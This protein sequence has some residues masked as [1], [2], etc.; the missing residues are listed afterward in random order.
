MRYNLYR[1]TGEYKINFQNGFVVAYETSYQNM[2]HDIN[3]NKE[4]KNVNYKRVDSLGGI[5]E[6]EEYNLN[7][8]AGSKAEND[9]IPM[10]IEIPEGTIYTPEVYFGIVQN[11]DPIMYLDG[12]TLASKM[13]NIKINAEDNE[14]KLQKPIKVAFNFYGGSNAGVYKYVYGQWMY[15]PTKF[16]EGLIYTE[17]PAVDYNGGSY[18][19]FVDNKYTKINSAMLHWAY[20]D[21]KL[22]IKRGLIPNVAD[23]NPDENITRKEFARLIYRN[24][25]GIKEQFYYATREFIDKME[26]K[27]YENEINFMVA[28]NYM[29]GVDVNV[30]EPDG[31][32]TYAQVETVINRMFYDEYSWDDTAYY[33]LT[34]RFHKSN[35]NEYKSNYISKA[36]VIYMLNYILLYI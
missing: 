8:L 21:I 27:E 14:V 31:F 2:F 30:F 32:I 5:V 36:E 17:I 20:Q 24:T 33:M 18:A 11:Q 6:Y 35:V 28:R 3:F 10:Y 26:F 29:N 7:Y 19:V 23:F 1:D 25:Y 9:E 34:N 13:Y 12:K 16:E 4:I 15:L 22:F